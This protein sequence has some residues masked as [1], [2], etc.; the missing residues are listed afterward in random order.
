MENKC[1]RI[2]SFDNNSSMKIEIEIPDKIFDEVVSTNA[3]RFKGNRIAMLK[4]Q[5]QPVT[6]L[7]MSDLEIVQKGL[8][9]D[10][11]AHVKRLRM[12]NAGKEFDNELTDGN[13]N[14]G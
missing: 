13:D 12:R 2:R 9:G 10:L 8:A 11:I 7:D 1:K 6:E 3:Q 14:Q 4:R 5:G